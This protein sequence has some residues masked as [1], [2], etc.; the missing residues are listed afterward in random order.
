MTEVVDLKASGYIKSLIH[1]TVVDRPK[2]YP[3]CFA[4]LISGIRV[5]V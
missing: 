1:D 3:Q 5:G 4:M 2:I